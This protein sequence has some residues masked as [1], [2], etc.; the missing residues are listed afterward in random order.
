MYLAS[1]IVLNTHP[2]LLLQAG[3]TFQQIYLRGA[4]SF[5]HF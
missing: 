4:G 5:K 2:H 3:N 1:V